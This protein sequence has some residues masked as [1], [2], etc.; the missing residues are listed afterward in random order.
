MIEARSFL[1]SFLSVFHIAILIISA[2]SI[3]F[4]VNDLGI[5]LAIFF[6][7][8]SF[9]SVVAFNFYH[10]L[11]LWKFIDYVWIFTALIS[12][13]FA[14]F[15]IGVERLSNQTASKSERATDRSLQ[16]SKNLDYFYS[17]CTAALGRP[18]A[19]NT[20][21]PP[22][23]ILGKNFETDLCSEI[24]GVQIAL[25]IGESIEKRGLALQWV[26]NNTSRL[27]S[28]ESSEMERKLLF[29][30]LEDAKNDLNEHRL[31]ANNYRDIKDN[32]LFMYLSTFPIEYIYYIVSFFGALRLAKTTAE[33]RQSIEKN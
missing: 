18:I 11:L 28:L 5:G 25:R 3:Y 30:S 33:L 27:E 31:Y 17:S 29:R 21:Q 9:F 20:L 24:K 22:A 10:V 15:N 32:Y 14:L 4:G 23:R 8:S 2:V 6:V 1:I 19:N 13:F 7:F 12:I 16:V 26:E